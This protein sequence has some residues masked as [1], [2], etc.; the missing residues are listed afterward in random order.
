MT[1]KRLDIVIEQGVDY[2]Q[3]FDIPAGI[4]LTGAEAAMQIRSAYGYPNALLTLTTQ[5]GGLAINESTRKLAASFTASVAS[6]FFAG[7]YVYDNLIRE[8]GGKN[9]RLYQGAAAVTAEVTE[10]DFDAGA[11]AALLLRSGGFFLLRSGGNI[12]LRG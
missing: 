4:Q 10:F 8:E 7:R 12:L 3:E 11:S 5:N 2:Y 6:A 1:A 9:T